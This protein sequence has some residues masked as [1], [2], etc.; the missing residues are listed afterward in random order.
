VVKEYSS[1][2]LFFWKNGYSND[3]LPLLFYGFRKTV[4]QG[5]GVGLT[6][7]SAE[8]DVRAAVESRIGEDQT[9]SE[10]YKCRFFRDKY[11]MACRDCAVCC[12]N[13]RLDRMM[14]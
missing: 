9:M 4:P 14:T 2:H 10:E 11:G 8:R 13:Y 7:L 6:A 12:P 3:G 5:V 1:E